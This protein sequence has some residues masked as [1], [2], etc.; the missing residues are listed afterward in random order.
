MKT[1]RFEFSDYS[2]L[3]PVLMVPPLLFFMWWSQEI[4]FTLLLLNIWV[5]SS[6]CLST[7]L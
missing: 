7:H 1:Y 2:L 4:P 5:K 6:S 3:K